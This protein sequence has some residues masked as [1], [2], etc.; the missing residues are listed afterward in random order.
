M[1][2]LEIE[3]F[4]PLT[5]QLSLDLD[6]SESEKSKVS[7]NNHSGT[8]A[9][10][11]TDFNTGSYILHNNLISNTLTVDASSIVFKVDKKPNVLHR[12]LYKVLGVKWD[13][14]SK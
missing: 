4:W 12:V 9:F 6:Y 10:S 11:N 2:Q 8:V 5:Q 14:K 7:Y 13:V 3:F 1:K